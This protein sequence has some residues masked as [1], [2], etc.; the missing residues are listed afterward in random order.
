ML[1]GLRALICFFGLLVM[2]YLEEEIL[3]AYRSR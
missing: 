1:F 2:I 3:F